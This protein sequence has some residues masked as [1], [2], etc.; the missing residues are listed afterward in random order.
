MSDVVADFRRRM[1]AAGAPGLVTSSVNEEG[2]KLVGL[3]QRKRVTTHE[4]NKYE[5]WWGPVG[6]AVASRAHWREPQLAVERNGRLFVGCLAES[7]AG[8]Y[9]SVSAAPQAESPADLETWTR[10]CGWVI[11]EHLGSSKR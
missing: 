2:E 6:L 8:F 10:V 1:E 9:R 7:K 11:A 4:I 5:M 3:L